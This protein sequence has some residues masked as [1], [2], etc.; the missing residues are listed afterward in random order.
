MQSN[1]YQQ[2]Q[3]NTPGRLVR[4]D[5]IDANRL[6]SVVAVLTLIITALFIFSVSRTEISVSESK[7]GWIVV[8]SGGATSA[9]LSHSNCTYEISDDPSVNSTTIA[10]IVQES[11][12]ASRESSNLTYGMEFFFWFPYFSHD[13]PVDVCMN[14]TLTSMM[15]VQIYNYSFYDIGRFTGLDLSP[16]NDSRSFNNSSPEEYKFVMEWAVTITFI[17]SSLS[18][19]QF[20]CNVSFSYTVPDLV[21]INLPS[22]L[23]YTS[24]IG[25]VIGVVVISMVFRAWN[26]P[27]LVDDSVG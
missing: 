16:S 21:A 5:E 10:G 7:S 12:T 26:Y 22:S 19:A 8:S 14:A 18:N 2:V 25:A 23:G 6:V 1:L 15:P 20:F 24:L 3:D 27:R 13:Y 11:F 17:N 9:S 4:L